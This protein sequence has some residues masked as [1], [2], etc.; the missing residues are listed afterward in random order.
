MFLENVADP[1]LLQQI[2]RETGH[3][4]TA[5]LYSDALSAPHG[6]ASTYVELMR[7]NTDTLVSAMLGE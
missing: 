4:P 1:R 2:G 6:P 3:D 5:R 7:Y